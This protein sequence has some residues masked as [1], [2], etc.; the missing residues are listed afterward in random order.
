MPEC[1]AVLDLLGQSP[2]L[3]DPPLAGGREKGGNL[4]C[5]G[6]QK[7]LSQPPAGRPSLFWGR[8]SRVPEEWPLGTG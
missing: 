8:G 6:R 7:S 4:E 1:K 3:Q 2:T 5:S